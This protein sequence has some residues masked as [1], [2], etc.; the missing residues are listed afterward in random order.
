[1][2]LMLLWCSCRLMQSSGSG[3]LLISNMHLA[4]YDTFLVCNSQQP[5]NL[6]VQTVCK[7]IEFCTYL[8]ASPCRLDYSSWSRQ[9]LPKRK[10]HKNRMEKKS[11][12][13]C[14]KAG[15]TRIEGIMH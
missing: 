1:M 4:L 9:D 5:W 15:T 7:L 2:A 10:C 6:S 12:F 8:T 13:C 3:L 14:L 11:A